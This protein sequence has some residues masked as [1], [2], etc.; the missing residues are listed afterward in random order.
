MLRFSQSVFAG[1]ILSLGIVLAASPAAYCATASASVTVN[2]TLAESLTI[3]APASMPTIA[4][5]A[6]GISPT[7]TSTSNITTSWILTSASNT[8]TL[9]ASFSTPTAALTDQTNGGTGTIPATAVEG[10]INGGTLTPFSS[11]GSLVLFTDAIT[12]AHPVGNRSDSLNMA[13]N[14]T[15]VSVP[16]DTYQGTL[17]LTAQAN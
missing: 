15:G 8:V 12:A 9:T 10:A 14:L 3:T 5:V 11:G 4:L 17:T 16:A 1:L 6:G 13:I 7:V 2:A